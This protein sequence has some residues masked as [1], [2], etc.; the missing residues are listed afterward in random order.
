MSLIERI[1]A[2]EAVSDEGSWWIAIRSRSKDLAVAERELIV[3]ALMEYRARA[4]FQRVVMNGGLSPESNSR[5]IEHIAAMQRTDAAAK[6][7][8]VEW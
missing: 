3:A 6:K 7:A 4:Y 2:V 1:K 8:G 5:E